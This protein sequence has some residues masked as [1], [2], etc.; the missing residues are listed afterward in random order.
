M[1]GPLR[2]TEP[3]ER[4]LAGGWRELVELAAATAAYADASSPPNT[5]RGYE[6]DWRDSGVVLRVR[7]ARHA[8]S[9]P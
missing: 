8:P 7:R 6:S 3:A 2:F 5:T 9:G 4:Q 1:A